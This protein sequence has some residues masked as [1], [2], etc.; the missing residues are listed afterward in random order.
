M[1]KLIIYNLETNL[2]SSTLA[3]THDWIEAFAH[4]I[5]SVQV[6]STHV[7]MHKLP[8]NVEVNELGGGNLARRI[9]ALSR[10]LKSVFKNYKYRKELIVFHHMSAH[11]LLIVGLFYKFL[12]VKQGLWYSHS[13]KSFSLKLSWRIADRIFSSMPSAIPISGSKLRFVGHGLNVKAFQSSASNPEL[14]RSGIVILGRVA[15]IKRIENIIE[16]VGE[17]PGM[18]MKI[19]C[20]GSKN[21]YEN[22]ALELLSIAADHGQEMNLVGAVSYEFLPRVL[23]QYEFIFTGTPKSVDKSVIEG[24]LAGCFVLSDEFQ[25]LKLTGMSEVWSDLGIKVIPR[26]SNQIQILKNLSDDL[27]SMLRKKLSNESDAL[28]NVDNTTARILHELELSS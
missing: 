9:L 4:Q 13:K 7:G 18:P 12:G 6:F 10:L 2:N 5:E 17:L 26:I 22:Y 1:K 20:I 11:T 15:P 28:N 14:S 8:K 3:A 21:G 27:K 23:C 19:D 25:A 16:A 24:S